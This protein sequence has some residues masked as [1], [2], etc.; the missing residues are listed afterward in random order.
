LIRLKEDQVMARTLR[1]CGFTL[2][3]L[4]V[5]IAIITLLMALLLPAVQKV[6]EAANRMQCG[7]N[8]KQLGIALHNHHNDWAGFPAARQTT[9]T[10]HSWVPYLLP[11]IELDNLHKQYDFKTDWNDAATNDR[12]PGGPNSTVIKML[13]C[14]SAPSGRRGARQRGITDYAPTTQITRPNPFLQR[15]PPSDP[16]YIGVMGNNVRRPIAGVYDG[17]SNTTILAEQAGLNERWE[18]GQFIASSG[19]TGAW[20]NPGNQVILSGF[21][22]ATRTIPGPCGVNCT[23]IDE[24]YAFHPA[25]A[26]ILLT[27]GS[28]HLLKK[29][30]DIN[31]VVPLMTRNGGEQIATDAF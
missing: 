18:M 6:R 24:I 23:N 28:V 13:V 12:L 26:Q 27:D 16:S 8:L 21:N 15:V 17:T 2:I 11:Y 3:E 4:L 14:P 29:Q 10:I 20:A 30:T 5:V 25:G 9:P 31:I 19:G 1:R 22:P 7:N